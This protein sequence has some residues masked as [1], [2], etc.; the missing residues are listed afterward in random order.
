MR[1]DCKIPSMLQ[2]LLRKSLGN[3]AYESNALA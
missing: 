2:Q 1:T 3:C